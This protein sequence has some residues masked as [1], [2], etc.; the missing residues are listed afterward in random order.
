MSPLRLL[1]SVLLL[2]LAAFAQQRSQE[3]SLNLDQEVNVLNGRVSF[4]F[5][6]EAVN[7]A[8]GTGL[9]S[10]DPNANEETR[11]MLDIGDNRVVFFAREL[12][13]TAGLDLLAAVTAANVKSRQETKTLV[14]GTSLR[15]I[16]STPTTFDPKKEAILVNS[17]LVETSDHTLLQIDA[18]IN[19]AAYPNRNQY[20]VVAETV[21]S[22]AKPGPRVVELSAHMQE[23]TILGGRKLTFAVP[24]GYTLTRDAKYDFQVFKL[25]HYQ[26]WTDTT[27]RQLII[28]LGSH[29]SLVYRD[30]NLRAGD[31]Q[32]I[33]GAFLSRPIE[34]LM[35]SVPKRQLLLKEQVIPTDGLQKQLVF[36]V[37]MLS[38]QSAALDELTHIVEGM[39]LAL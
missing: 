39:K 24:A 9:M 37:A 6:T 23:F 32:K 31:A 20:R 10:A 33:A 7:S 17:A 36:H 15:V 38:D 19:P 12:Y 4:K 25:H 34:W 27:W 8:R 29:P 22:T 2:P 35:F 13:K 30:M 11:I 14:D 21:F 28:Y 26:P 18:Y 3:V 5:P 1:L 16:L